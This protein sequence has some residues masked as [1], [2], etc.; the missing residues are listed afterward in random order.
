MGVRRRKS[1]FG[2]RC[3]VAEAVTS[4][5]LLPYGIP[6]ASPC[7]PT[8]VHVYAS[9]STL[10]LLNAPVVATFLV[11]NNSLVSL[12][13]KER[14]N[15]MVSSKRFKYA[16][17]IDV[18]K[19]Y[20]KSGS[21]DDCAL[22]RPCGEKRWNTKRQPKQNETECYLIHSALLGLAL[23]LRRREMRTAI[24]HALMHPKDF[25]V[26]LL[27]LSRASQKSSG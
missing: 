21:L 18:S 17:A 27:A 26:R 15:A 5:T 24:D 19:C 12:A 9:R 2:G 20:P 7:V 16:G 1:A 22:L 25:R 23:S 11:H 10:R 4:Y 8:G 6:P 14:R 13:E 3:L